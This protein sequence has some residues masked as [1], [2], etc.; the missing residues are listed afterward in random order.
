V[1]EL[2]LEILGCGSVGV[3]EAVPNRGVSHNPLA[4]VG[5]FRS[6]KHHIVIPVKCFLI[7]HP[8]GKKILVDTAWDSQV[9]THPI[10]TITFPMWVASKPLLPEGEAIDEQLSRRQM[11]PSDLAY[12]ILTHMD[13]DHDSGLR[14]IKEAPHILLSPEE[15]KA[16]HST[17]PRYVK[18]PYRGIKLETIVWNGNYGP[19]G[20]S[21]DIFGDGSVIVFLTPGHSEGSLCLKVEKEGQFALV[22]GDSGYNEDSWT[23]GNLPG[24]IYSKEDLK[25]TLSWIQQ[26]RLLPN[27]RG[28]FC[29]HDPSEKSKP[30]TLVF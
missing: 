11:K 12:V 24:P 16:L 5:L 6:K 20:K 1:A 14:L 29:A 26:Q 27:C 2:T 9:R 17:D 13:I 3:D 21:W 22:V 4:F 18:K 28:V 30:Q 19:F 8:S 25:K 10:G 7:T 23:K 15:G